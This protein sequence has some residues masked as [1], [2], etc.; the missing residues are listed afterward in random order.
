MRF[1]KLSY[2]ALCCAASGAVVFACGS[3]VEDEPLFGTS[4]TGAGGATGAGGDAATSTSSGATTT[5]SATAS[6]ASSSS[7]ASSSSSGAG[8]GGACE[9][10]CD[11]I[12]NECGFGDVCSQAPQLDCDSNPN[13]D[14][15][16]QCILDARC[17]EIASLAGSNPDPDLV[18]CGQACNSSGQGGAGG[19]GGG[20]CQGCA[21]SSCGQEALACV[22]DAECGDW[23]DCVQNCANAAC[24]D[25]C[26]AAHIAAEPLYSALKECLCTSCGTECAAL[27]PCGV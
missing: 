9:Q 22:T 19:G 6:S 24:V 5:G 2:L 12:A 4:S 23:I 25:A 8:G 10:A 11:K 16:G 3:D 21:Q 26:D 1:E 27:D 15:F 13:A 17:G 14:C 20:D 18:A 7:Q